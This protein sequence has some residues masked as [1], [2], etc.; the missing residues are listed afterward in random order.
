MAQKPKGKLSP[1]P[2]DPDPDDESWAQSG[3]YIYTSKGVFPISKLQAAERK[4]EKAKS[5]QL[6]EQEQWLDLNDLVPYPFEASN[7]LTLKDNCAYFDACIKQIAKDVVGQGWTL[8]L[9]EGKKESNQEKERILEF[10]ETC[11]G[12]RDET[13]EQTLERAIIDWG[14]IGWW[15]WEVGRSETGKNKGLVNGF[16]HVPAQTVYVH[17]K[18]KKYAQVRGDKKVWF[19]RFGEPDDIELHTGK[20]WEAPEDKNEEP[21]EKANE[22]IFFRNYYPQSDYYGAPNILSSIGA[23]M[24]LIGVRDYNLSFFENYGI[25]AAI[26]ILKGRWSKQTAKQISDFLDVEIKGSENAHKTMCIHPSKD[27]I[28]EIHEL[29]AQAKE[30]SFKIYQ[31]GLRDEILSEY[32]MPPYRIGIAETGSLG[33]STAGESTKIYAG[34]VVTPLE[35]TVEWLV[36]KKIFQEGLKCEN[37]EFQLK[38]LDLRDLDA[39]AARDAIYFG[40]GALTSNQILARKGKQ[41]YEEGNRYFVSSTYVEIGEE[42]MEK[43]ATVLKAV[44]LVLKGK[45]KLAAQ[46]LKIA[47]RET[48]RKK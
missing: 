28:F 40:L 12:D 45:P 8:E 47:K 9:R 13:F 42:P 21:K 2:P 33:G 25:P 20:E 6:E 14:L 27:S 24:G 36:T 41:P 38:E 22:L 26:I 34:S 4:E 15:A 43:G 44:E 29:G 30:A 39:E 3:I 23:V 37:Y 35:E 11:G 5:K 46:V 17:K 31:K 18:H 16:W 32:K 1:A 10:I 7:L 48:G 19:K